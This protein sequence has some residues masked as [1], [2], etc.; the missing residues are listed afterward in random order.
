MKR[1]LITL[2]I[3][4]AGLAASR[5]FCAV[6]EVPAMYPTIQDAVSA[7]VVG[8]TVLVADGTYFGPGNRDISFE[9]KAILVQSE[10]GAEFCTIDCMGGAAANHQAFTFTNGE[11]NGSHVTG[12]RIINSYQSSYMADGGAIYIE[13]ASPII[14]DCT[15]E[16]NYTEDSGSAIFAAGAVNLKI[17]NCV[18][19]TN[20]TYE[21]SGGGTIHVEES[22]VEI[23]NCSFTDN[24][25]TGGVF[26]GGAAVSGEANTGMVIDGC[27]FT[28]N[29]TL[30]SAAGAAIRTV[31]SDTTVL[32]CVFD[33]N[34]SP[35][36]AG[37]IDVIGTVL[38]SN[39]VFTGNTAGQRGGAVYFDEDATGSVVGCTFE[40]NTANLGG[41]ICCS[42]STPQIG[43]SE[44]GANTFTGN[45]AGTGAD[46]ACLFVPET[47]VDARWNHFTGY[48]LSDY[49]VSPSAAFD[50]SNSTY[51]RE[52]IF[53]DV[54][55]AADGS[56]TNDGLSWDTAF[57]TVQYAVRRIYA[58]SGNP[59]NI[60]IGPGVFSPSTTGETFPLP[61]INHVSIRGISSSQT[62]LDA[63]ASAGI[64]F[65]HR[66]ENVTIED[67][68]VTGG[69]DARGG[70][71]YCHK[72]SPVIQRCEIIDNTAG[73]YRKEG[74][75]IYVHKAA[76]YIADCLFSLN[77]ADTGGGVYLYGSTS[78]LENCLI[79]S[80]TADYA[81]GGISSD[82]N[83][84]SSLVFNCTISG[85]T[86][87]DYGGG[88][89]GLSTQHSFVNCLVANNTSR[90]GAGIFG[91]CV[92]APL[93]FTNCTIT[94]NTASHQ[95]G[96]YLGSKIADPVMINCI[97][98]DNLPEEIAG[99]PPEITYS[100]IMGGFPGTGNI[101][102]DPL[103]TTG[104]YGHYYLSHTAAGQPADSPCI[105][106]GSDLAELIC[107]PTLPEPV[108][109]D[110]MTT[111]TD[112][113]ADSGQVDMGFHYFPEMPSCDHTGDVNFD[114]IVT[115][116]DAQQTFLIALGFLTPSYLEACAAD[117]NASG[118]VTA[119]DAQAVFLV[120]LGMGTCADG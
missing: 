42:F 96:G 38:I 15:F 62:I 73:L 68:T 52:P 86:S 120:A 99:I 5:A 47:P 102:S 113:I 30:S 7:A 93:T 111:R 60:Y 58:T 105:D 101:D 91:F 82:F 90:Y 106:T 10:N 76:P 26:G 41:A 83:D 55:V 71:I 20:E 53:Q 36:H 98:W 28:G 39:C 85:N 89:S 79:I 65:I 88:I 24:E 59:L 14:S 112:A 104:V 11:G 57:Q 87:D 61:A 69:F 97:L 6:L 118:D 35:V 77:H 115:A 43:G 1:S 49:Y 80:N 48:Y 29:R 72:S 70:G 54:Y 103:F 13:N 2:I 44:T 37:A 31:N 67:L 95:G 51:V 4:A 66:D 33:D 75:G 46:I 22:H 23:T 12:F 21:T 17:Q 56:N 64:F 63:E 94:G 81:G 109:L 119:G 3:L 78:I 100:A 108:C 18:F 74:G 32:N 45:F 84:A 114:G 92:G 25:T 27:T 110:T 117:C 50:L 40:N 34:Y 9:G 19:N 107:A 116:N 8:D 16:M